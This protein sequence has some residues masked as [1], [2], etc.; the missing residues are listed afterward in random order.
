MKWYQIQTTLGNT[1]SIEYSY[2]EYTIQTLMGVGNMSSI[3]MLL[4]K[5]F[6]SSTFIILSKINYLILIKLLLMRVNMKCVEL[7]FNEI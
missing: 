6:S 2:G 1:F 5:N 7:N 4:F 3:I